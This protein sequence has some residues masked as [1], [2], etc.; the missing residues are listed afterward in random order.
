[1]S[2]FLPLCSCINHVLSTSSNEPK[3][4]KELGENLRLSQNAWHREKFKR[5]QT[6]VTQV[7]NKNMDIK[8][9]KDMI[10]NLIHMS[11]EPGD[12]THC[13]FKVT[14]PPPQKNK[15][16]KV[17]RKQKTKL[18]PPVHRIKYS[19]ENN[20]NQRLLTKLQWQILFHVDSQCAHLLICS[21][22]CCL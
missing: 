16:E 8:K 17:K 21:S 18:H 7:V 14:P 20:Q 15:M 6:F 19:L 11:G 13:Y 3:R 12:D 22:N 5:D 10:R 9:T 4:N 1:M 2:R